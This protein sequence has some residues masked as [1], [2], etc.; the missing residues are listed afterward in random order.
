MTDSSEQRTTIRAALETDESAVLA[1]MPE[2]ADFE[3][4]TWR[5]PKDLWEGDA[6]LVRKHFAGAADGVTRLLVA[7]DGSDQ[8]LGLALVT[9]GEESLSHRPGA[10]LEAIVVAKSGRG[11]GLGRPLM[12]ATEQLAIEEGAQTLTLNAF[13]QNLRA[14][15]LYESIGFDG[16]LIRYIKR[17]DSGAPSGESEQT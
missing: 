13:R 4:P 3:L 6:R 14:R 16:E 10:H 5:D 2:L 15:S 12:A 7:V 17:L 1:L 8:V 11:L 9:L